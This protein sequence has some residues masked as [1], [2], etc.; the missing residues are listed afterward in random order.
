MS[1][2]TTAGSG[3]T[4]PLHLSAPG[5]ETGGPSSAPPAAGTYGLLLQRPFGAGRWLP[6]W[7]LHLATVAFLVWE[8]RTS[9]EEALVFEQ[10]LCRGAEHPQRSGLE[11][12]EEAPHTFVS[13]D[14]QETSCLAQVSSCWVHRGS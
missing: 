12:E 5:V 1:S 8:G 4:L 13:R 7:H 6:W 10:L 3:E 9:D 11:E 14:C 2:G